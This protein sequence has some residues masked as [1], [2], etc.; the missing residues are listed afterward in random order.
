MAVNFWSRFN[1]YRKLGALSLGPLE[2]GVMERMWTRGGMCTVRDLHDDYD[3]AL[4]YTTLMTTVDRL[5]K[6]G[7]LDRTKDGKAFVYSTK[8]SRE[9]LDQRVVRDL[10]GAVVKDSQMESLPVLSCFVDAITEEDDKLLGALE[11]EIK[12]RRAASRK[13]RG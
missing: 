6:K 9:E 11:E 3:G 2:K 13:A 5:H 10:F 1:Q 8:L 4:A 12:K 7:L